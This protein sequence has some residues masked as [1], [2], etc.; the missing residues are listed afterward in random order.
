MCTGELQ[1]NDVNIKYVQENNF[2]LLLLI[3]M[4][5]VQILVHT[6]ECDCSTQVGVESILIRENNLH[7]FAIFRYFLKLISNNHF[8]TV[9]NE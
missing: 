2:K 6:R 3:Y 5:Y 1:R 4:L 9:K 8:P 7:C